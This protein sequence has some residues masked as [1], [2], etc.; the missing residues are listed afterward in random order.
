[1]RPLA[2]L[3]PL[4]FTA[5]SPA[6]AWRARTDSTGSTVHWAKEVTFLVDPE[7]G[8]ELGDENAR[9]A[10]D[11]ALA[12]VE[13]AAPGLRLS[14]VD[15]DGGGVGYDPAPGATNHSVIVADDVWDY[16][17]GLIAVTIVTVDTRRHE[18]LDADIAFNTR[19][20]R[21][22]VLPADSTP[23]GAFDDIQ[24]TLTHE[25]GHAVGL[26]HN[27]ELPEAVMYPGARRGEVTKRTLS[28]DDI[29]GL[30]TL[31]PDAQAEGRGLT[32]IGPEGAVGC[33]AGGG[34]AAV[35]LIGLLVPLWLWRRRFA[36][37]AVVTVA[38]SAL[39]LPSS[40]H[41]QDAASEAVEVRDAR[42][43][44]H[45][46]S[47]LT[48][49]VIVRHTL[50]REPGSGVLWSEL[51][52]R[53]RSCVKG[54]CPDTARIRVPG[55]REGDL[56]QIVDHQPVPEPGEVVALALPE[57]V[58][59]HRARPA[60][61]RLSD[62]RGWVRFA[63]ALDRARIAIPAGVPVSRLTSRSATTRRP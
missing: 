56:E 51:E 50:P 62:T 61:F 36:R 41:A 32:G 52:V 60:L 7:I 44:E 5:L 40:A 29:D 4:L 3:L 42:A 22:K 12:E 10:I 30:Q 39:C 13:R 54:S 14:A 47:V 8:A 19:H 35:W 11:A 18:I 31:Y 46:G 2:L 9:A 20:R 58:S 25:L 38:A 63:R 55:G 6:H 33:S 59:L 27:P 16:D 53:V 17:E 24:N 57:E 45:A 37:A 1:M 48:G 26:A 28:A 34:S 49:E 43:L 21:F 23:G 15:G